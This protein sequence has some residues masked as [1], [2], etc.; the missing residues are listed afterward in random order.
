MSETTEMLEPTGAPDA[1]GD[2]TGIDTGSGTN[3]ASEPRAA[4]SA[5]DT[6]ATSDSGR[7]DGVAEDHPGSASPQRRRRASGLAGMVLPELQAL[8][9]TLGIPGA[10]RLRKGQL[11]AAI[12]MAQAGNGG[13]GGAAVEGPV[14]AGSRSADTHR[15][16]H[17][18]QVQAETVPWQEALPTGDSPDT[19][20]N[21]D[22]VGT[23]DMVGTA[24]R[25]A[26]TSARPRWT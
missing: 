26:P 16:T 24:T 14:A 20:D 4:D 13:A 23:G 6:G 15:D 11:I 3:A 22:M 17:G 18:E 19:P 10:A 5:A 2:D 25:W 7:P 12:Q 9:S 1:L 8:A 21:A